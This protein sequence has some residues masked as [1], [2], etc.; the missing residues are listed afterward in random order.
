[1][2]QECRAQVIYF[3]SQRV[4]AEGAFITDDIIYFVLDNKITPICRVDEI[5]LRGRHNLE[6]ILCAVA[7]AV[8]AGTKVESIRDIL[9]TFTRSLIV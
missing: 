4:L 6:N 9:K 7:V 3:S 5:A 8:I 2:A 1:M